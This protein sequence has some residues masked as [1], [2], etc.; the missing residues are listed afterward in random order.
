MSQTT[1]DER[2][3]GLNGWVEAGLFVLAIS[4]LTVIYAIAQQA[5][6]HIVVFIL[7]AMGFAAAGMLL[8]TGAGERALEIA[9]ARQSLTF[10]LTTVLLEAF[11]FQLLSVLSPAETSLALRLSVPVSLIVGWLFFSREMSR[12][13]WIGSAI[14]TAAVAPILIDVAPGDRPL[15]VNLALICSFIVTFK[16]FA[17]EF[18]PANRAARSVKD[19]LRVTGLVVLATTLMGAAILLPLVLSSAAGLVPDSALIPKPSQFLHV[20]TLITAIVL[21]AP[22]F[23][24]MTY[25]T[26]SSV[27]KIGTESFLATSAFTP[28]SVL[29]IETVAASFGLIRANNFDVTLL[30]LIGLGIVGVLIVVRARHRP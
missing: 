18:H 25:L 19:K 13:L 29:A 12:P 7:Y 11:Y 4:V 8:I 26:F 9:T 21:G 30:P 15:A 1:R 5:G 28:F 27:V 6:A 17:S 16:T 3:S 22:V 20:P 24:A 10:G 2:R 14:I 23:V